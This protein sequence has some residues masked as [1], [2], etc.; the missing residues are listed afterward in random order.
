MSQ[1][2]EIRRRFLRV[3]V[4][5]SQLK[6]KLQKSWRISY[7]LYWKPAYL[8]LL[9]LFSFMTYRVLS[10]VRN[11][12]KDGNEKGQ[13]GMDVKILTTNISGLERYMYQLI[14]HLSKIEKEKRFYIFLHQPVFAFDNK[15]GQNFKEEIEKDPKKLITSQNKKIARGEIDLFHVTWQDMFW[16]HNLPLL[17]SDKSVITIHDLINLLITEYHHPIERLTYKI[18]L[19][20]AVRW[21]DRIIAVS[22]YTKQD[23]IKHLKADEKKI[24]VIYPA[25]DSRFQPILNRQVIENMKSKYHIPEKYILTVGKSYTHKN[26]PHLIKAFKNLVSKENIGHKLVLVGEKYWGQ[27]NLQIQKIIAELGLEEKVIWFGYV[28]DEDMPAIYN[29]AD[30]FVLPSYYEGFGLPVLEAMACGTPLIASNV[31]SI[32]EVV[33]DAGILVSPT[34]VEE[35]TRSM[36]ALLKDQELRNTLIKKGLERSKTFSWEKCARETLEVYNELLKS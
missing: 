28:D 10:Y 33:G 5:F 9:S 35:L 4:V 22:E 20:C 29:G 23:I 15:V 19:K 7:R 30:L 26:I 11:S 36:A 18:M 31:T 14:V 2:L 16:Y 34:D 21:A 32:P 12:K 13:I 17:W 1:T 25:T 3:E 6:A 27:A 8:N 24:K